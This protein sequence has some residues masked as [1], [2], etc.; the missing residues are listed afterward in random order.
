MPLVGRLKLE[1]KVARSW[2]SCQLIRISYP[3]NYFQVRT[4]LHNASQLF[5]EE[6]NF[7]FQWGGE[8][9]RPSKIDAC[10][11]QPSWSPL[12]VLAT[13]TT[14]QIVELYREQSSLTFQSF[15]LHIFSFGNQTLFQLGKQLE[16]WPSNIA[17]S[18][19]GFL[20]LLHTSSVLLRFF[21]NKSP[22]KLLSLDH[23]GK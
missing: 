2:V 21:Q 4:P 12:A 22:I 19:P 1:P 23:L 13:P 9:L 3:M 20:M 11:T 7:N 8:C 17:S 5:L 10:K 18:H 16:F 15:W 6:V 14:S